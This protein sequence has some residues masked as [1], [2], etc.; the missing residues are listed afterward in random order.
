VGT[1]LTSVIPS[2]ATRSSISR[3]FIA[4]AGNLQLQ[5]CHMRAMRAA[6]DVRDVRAVPEDR[7]R[8]AIEHAWLVPRGNQQAQCLG[9]THN[10]P[11]EE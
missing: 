4:G 1:R 9:V 5:L 2:R 3:D 6:R 11:A 7:L 10:N 8:N